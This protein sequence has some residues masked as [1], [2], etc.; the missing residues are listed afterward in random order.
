MSQVLIQFFVIIILRFLEQVNLK[1][2]SLSFDDFWSH[3]WSM[4][5]NLPLL[6]F[7]FRVFLFWLETSK[8]LN[9]VKFIFPFSLDSGIVRGWKSE[10]EAWKWAELDGER[11]HDQL[12]VDYEHLT[13]IWTL[14]V[15]EFQ[16]RERVESDPV[17]RKCDKKR[18]TIQGQEATRRQICVSM[19][20][21][22]IKLRV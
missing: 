8:H 20:V 10:V 9:W 16:R 22:L 12:R 2:S 5:P 17:S 3:H 19:K 18:R 7:D 6:Q 4:N 1:P 21:S 11:R 14:I 15:L 13:R